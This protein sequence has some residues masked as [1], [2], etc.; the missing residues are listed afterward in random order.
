MEVFL[1]FLSIFRRAYKQGTIS[2]TRNEKKKNREE[3]ED[4]QTNVGRRE[5]KK[6]EVQQKVAIAT[7]VV[8]MEGDGRKKDEGRERREERKGRRPASRK[9]TQVHIQA[10]CGTMSRSNLHQGWTSIQRRD[11]DVTIHPHLSSHRL[12]EPGQSSCSER[13][14]RSTIDSVRLHRGKA[15]DVYSTTTICSWSI[16][17]RR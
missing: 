6:E 16:M 15:Y 10:R 11:Q 8:G 4:E 3:K 1:S 12:C 7:A 14:P 13:R 5:E 17:V 9:K 2:Y